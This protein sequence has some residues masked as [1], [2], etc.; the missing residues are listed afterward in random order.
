VWCDPD[1]WLEGWIIQPHNDLEAGAREVYDNPEPM[2]VDTGLLDKHG[3]PI[4]RIVQ[5]YG[6]GFHADIGED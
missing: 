4:H 5:R 1:P 6:I 2:E 3:S